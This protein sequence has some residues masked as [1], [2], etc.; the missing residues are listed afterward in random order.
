MLQTSTSPLSQAYDAGIFDLD[1]VCYRGSVPIPH[2]AES[3]TAATTDGLAPVF[4]TNNA[5]RGPAEVAERLAGMGFPAQAAGVYTATM[6]AADLAE[7]E[8]APGA[9]ILIIGGPAHA[10]ELAGRGFRIVASADDRP[11]AVVQGL[12]PSVDW[13]MLSEG[14]LAIRAGARH[15]ASN[16]DSTL[17]QERGFML[18]NGS[19]VAAVEHATGQKATATGKP[20]PDVFER[21][22]RLVGGN[23]PMAI[24]DRLNTD[25]AG[26]VAAGMDCLHVLTGVSSEAD[27][28]LA[29]P[30]ER[31]SYVG[32]DL[33]ALLEP[34]EAPV[35]E[36]GAWRLGGA[37]ARYTDALEASEPL[38]GCS[39]EVYRCVVAAC[40]EAADRGA[41]RGTLRGQVEE[42]VVARD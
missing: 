21:A 1:G 5:S 25:I 26:A 32:R 20:V 10:E 16:I 13:A 35:A 38:A 17:P 4:L 37:W 18:G 24:G 12:H 31:P 39:M 30:A 6:G 42:M 11:D 15:L 33:R 27:V 36:D 7:A 28:A 22:A 23:R 34:H 9:S 29:E 40:W 2:A 3:V 14:A 41:D 8:L 19:L